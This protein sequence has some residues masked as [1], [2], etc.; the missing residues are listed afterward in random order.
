[1]LSIIQEADMTWYKTFSSH[2]VEYEYY[3]DVGSGTM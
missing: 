2:R 1:M 3:G